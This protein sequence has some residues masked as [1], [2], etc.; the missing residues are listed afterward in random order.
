MRSLLNQLSSSADAESIMERRPGILLCLVFALCH[1]SILP[2]LPAVTVATTIRVNSESGQDK[3]CFP[4][5]PRS[6]VPCKS[7]EHVA[8]AFRGESNLNILIETDIPLREVVKFEHVFNITMKGLA[9][10]ERLSK[11]ILVTCLAE[12]ESALFVNSVK[13]FSIS[14]VE[15]DSCGALMQ[16]SCYETALLFNYSSVVTLDNVVLTKSHYTGLA[17]LVCFGNIVLNRVFLYDNGKPT[18][19][20]TYPA[21]ASIEIANSSTT[22]HYSLKDCVFEHNKAE[23]SNGTCLNNSCTRVYKRG[24]GG[25]LG[26]FITGS[27]NSLSIH[28]CEFSRNAAHTTGG[29]LY[30]QFEQLTFNNSVLVEKSRFDKN[31][32]RWVGGGAHILYLNYKK[33]S[34]LRNKV[35]FKNVTFTSNSAKTGGGTGI[36][37]VYSDYQHQ[38]NDTVVFESCHWEDNKAVFSAAIDISP[39]LGAYSDRSGFLP[40]PVFA[41]VHIFNNSFIDYHGRDLKHTNRVNAGVFSITCFSVFFSGTVT[42]NKNK[43]SALLLVSGI[44]VFTNNTSSYFHNNSGGSGGAIAMYGFSNIYVTHNTFFEFMSNS[45]VNHGGAIYYHTIDQHDFISELACFIQYYDTKMQKLSISPRNVTFIFSNNTAQSGGSSIYADSFMNCKKSCRIRKSTYCSIHDKKFRFVCCIGNFTFNDH[46]DSSLQSS[47]RDFNFHDTT[48]DYRFIP[49]GV[50]HVPFTVVDEFNNT[51]HPIMSI[52]RSSRSTPIKINPLYSYT[53]TDEI[54]LLGPPN[55]TTTLNFVAEGIAGVFFRF[56]VTTLDCPPGFIFSHNKS[57]CLCSMD[58]NTTNRYTDIVD[59]NYENY[60]AR[61]TTNCWAG[62]VPSDTRS[63]ENLYFAPCFEPLCKRHNRLTYLPNLTEKLDSFLCEENRTGVM[64][65]T[66]KGNYSAY[67]HSKDFVCKSNHRCHLGILFYLISEIAPTFVLFL[68]IVMFDLSF[69]SGNVVGFIFFCHFLDR[70]TVHINTTFTYL[71]VPYRL[72]YDIF[73]FDYFTIPHLSFCIWEG[74]Q[75]LD[76]ISFKYVTVLAAFALVIGFIFTVN[77]IRCGMLLK[78]RTKVSTKSSFVNGL[79]AFLVICYYQCTKTSLLIL[80]SVTPTGIEGKVSGTYTFYGGLPYFRGKHLIYAVPALFSLVFVTALPPLVLLLYPLSLHLLAICRLSESWIVNQ[81]LKITFT[82]KLKPFIDCFQSCYKDKLRF[83]AGL[84]F[85]YRVLLVCSFAFA[86][87][88]HGYRII[89]EILLLSFLGIHATVQPYKKRVHN[90]LDSLIF[91]NLALI[92]ILALH[93]SYFAEYLSPSEYTSSFPLMLI[94]VTQLLL[95]YLPMLVFFLC[96]VAK[97]WHAVRIW[98]ERK[99]RQGYEML[100]ECE[101]SSQN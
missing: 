27:G 58:F 63:S 30:V 24:I 101:N 44:A 16:K 60:S 97:G 53:L 82:N 42:F 55:Q 98:R 26:V 91:L 78:W 89:T 64:C 71:R 7:L 29:G 57:K 17:F 96:A 33:S 90:L 50:Y 65:G 66:C 38:P 32:A 12:N 62:Y 81:I 83:F 22:V 19:H 52:G 92:N 5:G 14:N 94:T 80:K 3:E 72:F 13:N 59:C 87:T 2:S 100:D 35:V 93:S 51:V 67:Y 6:T 4:P 76:V 99:A 1:W 70:F 43:F 73:N 25:G 18:C 79:S 61:I 31:N 49:G 54:S 48:F 85:V 37:S 39:Y 40:I 21:G 41:N 75:I 11:R 36:S 56:N 10:R 28:N 74:F 95:I 20:T 8:A 45:A 77:T 68:I 9:R 34:P 15:F 47:G 88:Y 84:Y 23:P 69:T 46:T 86:E